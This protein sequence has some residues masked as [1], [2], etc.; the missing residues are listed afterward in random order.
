MAH[1]LTYYDGNVTRLSTR[2]SGGLQLD[3]FDG[4]FNVSQYANPMPGLPAVGDSVRVGCN[5]K[6]YIETIEIIAQGPGPRPMPRQQ[7]SP[8]RPQRQPQGAGQQRQPQGQ[9]PAPAAA[10]PPVQAPSASAAQLGTAIKLRLE[11]TALAVKVFEVSDDLKP[12]HILPMAQRIEYYLRTGE[13]L[14]VPNTTDGRTNGT[15][16][17]TPPAGP[18]EA[19][20]DTA[21][22]PLPLA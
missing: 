8:E 11:A 5:N 21:Y 12:A 14:P 1:E 7:P 18:P 20:P 4:W 16:N 2:N 15:A 17:A 10:T 13:I 19:P 3:T 22:D 9:P 6:E